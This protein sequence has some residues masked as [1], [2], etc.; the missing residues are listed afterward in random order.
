MWGGDFY[1]LPLCVYCHWPGCGCPETVIML[2]GK[3]SYT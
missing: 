3:Y 1:G 2:R